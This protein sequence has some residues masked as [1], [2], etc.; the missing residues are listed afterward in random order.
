MDTVILHGLS[1]DRTWVY[2]SFLSGLQQS[3]AQIDPKRWGH[4]PL[5]YDTQS[6]LEA[7]EATCFY[8]SFDVNILEPDFYYR[9]FDC[10]GAAISFTYHIVSAPDY[11]GPVFL[12]IG[13][14]K[15]RAGSFVRP[16]IAFC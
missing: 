13:E 10:L 8:G 3:A 7:R 1:W 6:T 9:D 14:S 16:I 4:V 12:G 15:S 2:P 5:L 11:K